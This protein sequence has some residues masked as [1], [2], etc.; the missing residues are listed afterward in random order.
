MMA[1]SPADR[2]ASYDDVIR[3]IELASVEH[4]RPAGLWARSVTAVVDLLIAAAAVFSIVGLVSL[5]HA[6][7]RGDMGGFVFLVYAVMC[8]I[9]IARTGRSPGQ[10][11]FELEVVDV[12]TGGKPSLGRAAL[13]TVLPIAVAWPA[14][15][16]KYVLDVF[17]YKLDTLVGELAAA[18]VIIAPIGLVWASLRSVSKQTFWDKLSRTMVRYRTRRA[19]AI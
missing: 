14:N 9:L 8:T 1:T 13:R 4:A 15:V 10:W 12:V 5:V 17:G 3:A 2:F 18:T 19:P 6:R 7:L 16:L 11:L